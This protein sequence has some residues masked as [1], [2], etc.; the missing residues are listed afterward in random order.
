MKCEQCTTL[1]RQYA[2]AMTAHVSRLQ[3]EE[4]SI[5]RSEQGA[6]LEA[7]TAAARD[8]DRAKQAIIRHE[9]QAHSRI[10][11]L[12]CCTD[13]PPLLAEQWQRPR[14]TECPECK[15]IAEEMSETLAKAL[16]DVPEEGYQMRQRCTQVLEAK[17]RHELV[18]GHR[19][20]A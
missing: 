19:V 2:T 17:Q 16:C 7:L 14:S 4:Q 1:W 20:A 15:L 10:S 5:G 9:A 6:A 18:S 12:R 11:P 13:S 3:Q 8:H